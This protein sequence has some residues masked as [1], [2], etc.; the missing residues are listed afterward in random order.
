MIDAIIIAG[1]RFKAPMSERLKTD[2]LLESVDDVY[3]IPA[4]FRSS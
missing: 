4:E 2:F 3:L 1:P